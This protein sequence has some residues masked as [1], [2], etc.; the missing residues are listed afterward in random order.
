MRVIKR[1]RMEKLGVIEVVDLLVDDVG[2]VVVDLLVGGGVVTGG[3][4]GEVLIKP[5]LSILN[6]VSET[7]ELENPILS[8]DWILRR[9]FVP[10][11][12]EVTSHV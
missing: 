11:Y 5:G 7:E 4:V 12:S 2:S 9:T 3:V 6:D 8:V 10:W 1:S